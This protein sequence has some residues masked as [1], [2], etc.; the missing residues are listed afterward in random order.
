M[1][2]FQSVGLGGTFDRLHAGHKLFLDLASYYGIEI[3]IGL[4]GDE[5]LANQKKTLSQLIS[6]Y[7]KRSK[8]LHEY[9]RSRNK[10]CTI[11]KIN[12]YGKDREYARDSDLNALTVSQET[13][14]GAS[15]INTARL[16]L[17]K[18]PLTLIIVPFVISAN[19]KRLSSTML[20]KMNS[21]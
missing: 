14:Q 4:I 12:S 16:Q 8:N 7:D 3:Q 21:K 19:G 18:D 10:I 1:P 5:Y 6:N 2:K 15:R 20:R 17:K 13:F 11:V 9:C